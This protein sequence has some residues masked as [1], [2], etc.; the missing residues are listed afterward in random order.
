MSKGFQT[1]RL[2]TVITAGKGFQADLTSV[3]VVAL[4]EGI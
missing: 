4:G 2:S 1:D 3:P